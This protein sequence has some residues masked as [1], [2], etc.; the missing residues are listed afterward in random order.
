SL[1]ILPRSSATGPLFCADCLCHSFDGQPF[2]LTVE[3]APR[4]LI[5]EIHP[6]SE[7]ASLR[8]ITIKWDPHSETSEQDCIRHSVKF[9][10][11]SEYETRLLTLNVQCR[12]GGL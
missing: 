11:T 10:A 6:V 12:H 8:T 4:S 7:R 2:S 1:L 9:R 3:S 5:A